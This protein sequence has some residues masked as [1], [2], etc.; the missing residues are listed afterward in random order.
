MI[1]HIGRASRVIIIVSVLFAALALT[2]IRLLLPQ[3]QAY[4]AELETKVGEVLGAP[5]KI[6]RLRAH[7]ARFRPELIL[8]D[9]QVAAT[10]GP[11]P[12]IQLQE[13]R[14]GVDLLESLLTR[15]FLSAMHVSLVGA[16]LGVFRKADG[17]LAITGLKSG[18]APPLWLLQGRHYEVLQ[19][20]VVW[21]NELTGKPPLTFRD[22]DIFIVNDHAEERRLIHVLLDLPANLGHSL[23]L[24]LDAIGNMFAPG[25][26]NGRLYVEGSQVNLPALFAERLPQGLQAVS[27]AADVKLWSTWDKSRMTELLGD[28]RAT[29][30]R[31]FGAANQTLDIDKLAAKFRWRREAD[32]WQLQVKN[33]QLAA[34]EL[35]WQDE[36]FSLRA[37]V[38]GADDSVQQV[39]A[40]IPHLNIADSSRLAL[41]SRQLDASH[42]HLLQ[43]LRP[44]G[45][46]RNVALFVEPAQQAYAFRGEF[47][48]LNW[49]ALDSIPAV[50]RLSGT[51]KGSELG[52]TVQ[53]ASNNGK[54]D[55]PGL[56]REA[57]PVSRLAGTL[58]WR[59]EPQQWLLSCAALQLDTP[60]IETKSRLL[61][62]IPKGPE[63]AFIDLQTAFGNVNNVAEAKKYL[64]SKIMDADVVAWLDRALV[65]GTVAEG[66]GLLRG[67]LKDYPFAA[68][69]GVFQVLFAVQGL[70]LNVH[71][72][73][74]NIKH[75]DAEVQFLQNALQA[76]I[77]S[78]ESEGLRIGQTAAAIV[79]L[80]NANHVLLKGKVS[81][82]VQKGFAYLQK[83]PLRATVDPALEFIAGRGTCDADLD[84]K[85]PLTENAAAKVNGVLHLRNAELAV[86]PL[87]LPVQAITGDLLF[88][89][90]GIAAHGI[91]ARALGN[92]VTAD[93]SRSDEQIML[94]LDG[95]IAVANLAKA[96]PSPYWSA[97][98]GQTAYQL[99]LAFPGGGKQPASLELTSNLLGL[100]LD[101]PGTLRKTADQTRLLSAAF[102]FPDGA[103]LPV[104]VNYGD[105]LRASAYI[106][107]QNK[108]LFSADIL[109]TQ[110]G[111]KGQ[112]VLSMQPGVTIGVKQDSFALDPWL[113]ATEQGGDMGNRAAMLRAL[114]IET[115]HLRWQNNDLGPLTVKLQRNSGR[116]QGALTSSFAVGSISAP[117][118]F[119]HA[120]K[121]VLELQVLNL[122][123]L[124]ALQLAGDAISPLDLPALQIASR[125]LLWR[126]VDLGSLNLRA[127]AA[128]NGLDFAAVELRA[129]DKSLQLTGRWQASGKQSFSEAKGVLHC[130]ALGNLLAQLNIV[131]DVQETPGRIEFT[132][133]WPGAPYQVGFANVQ[134]IVDAEL[135]EGRMLGVNPGI[136]RVLGVLALDQWKRR[137]QL[138]FSDA[139]AEG[140][141]YNRIKGRFEL[142]GG[143]ALTDDLTIEAVPAKIEI[144]GK[145]GLA[146]RDWDQLVIV[147][148]KTS[149]ALPIA[150]PIAGKLITGAAS[151]V[152]EE[153]FV[154]ELKHLASAAYA[155]KGKWGAAEITPLHESDGLLRK[156][157][158]GMTDFS[159]LQ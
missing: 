121:L 119:T 135:D 31:L 75:I 151:L 116:W 2:G 73:W 65:S 90:Q 150:G 68:H 30:G 49:S 24:S 108:S 155:V 11:V 112:T 94:R 148:P 38:G 130:E 16:K 8:A 149:A 17:S 20:E 117:E 40:L 98:Q 86:L 36:T 143:Y 129:P 92:K 44:S 136:G 124:A 47:I 141:T 85:I 83:T 32:H 79:A 39:A 15:R 125:K 104:T 41:F 51:L 159:W 56:F 93:I 113:Q 139:Y 21:R 69:Q 84:L 87:Q 88:N 34:G 103:L 28:L 115:Q 127:D 114:N 80:E 138:D 55:F 37:V 48:D 91:K 154:E 122:S 100:T 145:T 101:L 99:R 29:Q 5:V 82:D 26:I 61:L 142:S 102:G 4:R 50:Q 53:L 109:L 12:A 105:E 137:L 126:S 144:K 110:Q 134:G 67:Y 133:H 71:P 60:D 7:I 33:L 78:G 54:I 89:E 107:K 13:I 59:Q 6:G 77:R 27:G 45:T 3:V 158:T 64:P 72:D 23:R 132:L 35:Q 22:V 95:R 43:H 1:Y 81:G 157:W 146:A 123:P 10:A 18:G 111:G 118:H 97:A 120:E 19:S 147:T 96:V 9:I 25:G 52:G 131:Q 58:Q 140:L 153:S 14:L 62:Q 46:L 70:E 128:A 66:A 42:A 57:L 63:P 76:D 152:A 156:V 74:P 106:D